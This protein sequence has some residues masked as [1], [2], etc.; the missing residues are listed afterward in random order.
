VKPQITYEDFRRLLTERNLNDDDPFDWFEE[1][2]FDEKIPRSLVAASGRGFV[3]I[4]V[5]T[6][7][8]DNPD[9]NALENIASTL[10]LA[11]FAL[12]WETREQFG[13]GDA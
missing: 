1:R 5:E 7:T 9:K 6:M 2:G 3:D 12:G 8:S 11:G 4:L 13:G 10:M